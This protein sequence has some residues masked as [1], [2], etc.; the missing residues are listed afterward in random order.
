MPR[1]RAELPDTVRAGRSP[2]TRLRAAATA[3]DDND[4]DDDD[5]DVPDDDD[6]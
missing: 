1:E 2:G 5:A 3:D 6:G 4:D